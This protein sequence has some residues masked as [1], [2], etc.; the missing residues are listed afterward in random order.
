MSESER[1]PTGLAEMRELVEEHLQ[2]RVVETQRGRVMVTREGVEVH[3]LEEIADKYREHPRRPRGTSWHGTMASLV[4]H[5]KR[6]A[7]PEIGRA[8]V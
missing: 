8:H 5:A 6:H 2:P 7:G 1:N 3:D 4:A